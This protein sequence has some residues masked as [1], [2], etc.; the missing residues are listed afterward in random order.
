MDDLT[1]LINK[2]INTKKK[3]Q[4]IF[5]VGST[6]PERV[7]NIIKKIQNKIKKGHPLFGTVPMRKD[8]QL[9][10]FPNTKKLFKLISWKSRISINS[11]LNKTIKSYK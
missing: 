1:N 11:G 9:K 5:N 2:I 7:V 4:G 3:I 8:E 10:Y 6:S